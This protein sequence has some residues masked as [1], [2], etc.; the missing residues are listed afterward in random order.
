MD[1]LQQIEEI[2]E[3]FDFEAVRLVMLCPYKPEYDDD[4]NVISRHSWKMLLSGNRFDTPTVAEL[5]DIAFKY[6][7]RAS[8]FPDEEYHY[9][10]SGP[11]K[12]SNRYGTLELEFVYNNWSYD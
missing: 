9:V 1:K 2:M 7:M 10:A 11:F 6:L 12:A 5:R 4:G 3:C 8:H